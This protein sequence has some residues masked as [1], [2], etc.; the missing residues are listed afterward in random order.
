M[1]KI[2]ILCVALLAT[3]AIATSCRDDESEFSTPGSQMIYDT[4]SEQ[5]IAIWKSMNTSY[6]MWDID[7]TDWDAVYSEYYPKFLALDKRLEDDE[8]ASVSTAELKELYEGVFST[9]IDHHLYIS[10]WNNWG[11]DDALGF[12]IAN[13][14]KDLISRDYFHPRHLNTK[15]F[16][17]SVA[18]PHLLEEYGMRTME[19]HSVVQYLRVLEAQGRATQ[20]RYGY[21]SDMTVISALIDGN[22]PYLH[23]DQFSFLDLIKHYTLEESRNNS[24]NPYAD[25]FQAYNSFYSNVRTLENLGGVIF[26]VRENYGGYIIDQKYLLGLLIDE[27]VLTGYQ[28]YKMGFGKYDYSPWTPLYFYPNDTLHRPG[29]NKPVVILADLYSVSMAEL[30]P[31]M[32]QQMPNGCVIG[33]R[34][35]GGHGVSNGDFEGQ[36]SGSF[37]SESGPHYVTFSDHPTRTVDG[38]SLEGIGISPDIPMKTVLPELTNGNDTW[39]DRAV[40]YIHTGH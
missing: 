19:D 23:F 4:P 24:Y 27:P 21:C 13:L 33:E 1:K 37:G 29:Y 12:Y 9:L 11:H 38:R 30:T 17:T 40:T 18:L 3:A 25:A 16:T 10:V 36:Y 31:M 26:D 22:I 39:I 6:V 5:F 32:A 7:S 34:T 2:I 8:D 15:V 20:I 35:V 28:H 14:T